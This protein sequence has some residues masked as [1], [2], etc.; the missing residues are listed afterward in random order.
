M[1]LESHS[2]TVN[3]DLLSDVI[4]IEDKIYFQVG[5]I[6]TTNNSNLDDRRYIPVRFNYP[7]EYD[8]TNELLI[9]THSG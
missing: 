2:K 5:L 7:M 8:P 6:E 9:S 4:Y 1:K 3:Y